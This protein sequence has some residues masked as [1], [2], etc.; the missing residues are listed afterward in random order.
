M[1]APYFHRK[2]VKKSMDIGYK[3]FKPLKLGYPPP[4]SDRKYPF[5]NSMALVKMYCT[6]KKTIFKNNILKLTI[7]V[8]YIL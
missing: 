7:C 3:T 8:V 1:L 2:T 4:K 6:S 5:L